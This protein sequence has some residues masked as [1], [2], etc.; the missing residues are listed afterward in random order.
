VKGGVLGPENF[1]PVLLC[2]Y[3]GRASKPQ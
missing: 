3:Y 2:K 1:I